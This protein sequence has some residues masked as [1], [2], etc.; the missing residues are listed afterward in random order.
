MIYDQIYLMAQGL[1]VTWDNPDI[2]LERPL[3]TRVSSHD[4]KPNTTYYVV[5]RVWNLSVVAPAPNLPVRMSYLRFGIGGG[6]TIIGSTKVDLP[7]KGSPLL[8]ARAMLPWRTPNTAG[9][10]CLQVE[11]LWP[12]VEDANPLNNVGQHNTDVKALAS[13][14]TFKIPVRNDDPDAMGRL[15]LRVDSYRLPEPDACP[16]NEQG[17]HASDTAAHNARTVARHGVGRFEVPEGWAVDVNPS[18]LSLGPHEE[19]DV[20]VT[21]TA[22]DG[23]AGR[24]AFNVNAFEGE[25][26]VGGVTL[27]VDGH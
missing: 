6:K 27:Y 10:Y 19:A 12:D 21:F 11:L 25:R 1:A 23:F 18:E 26:L 17:A 7:V 20:S 3:G 2:H 9:H 24:H 13:P 5:A 8:P 16:P 4:L 14:A 22:P 15:L